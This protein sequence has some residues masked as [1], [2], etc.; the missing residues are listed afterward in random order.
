MRPYDMLQMSTVLLRVPVAEWGAVTSGWKR[1]FRGQSG[2]ASALWKVECPVPRVAF[3]LDSLGRYSAVLMLLGCVWRERLMG[4]RFL[5]GV[6]VHASSSHA[7]PVR[8]SDRIGG[9][10][11]VRQTPRNQQAS[12]AD[13]SYTDGVYPPPRAPRASH[14]RPGPPH[15]P[16]VG[17]SP[18]L[19][20]P[21][22]RIL[23]MQRPDGPRCTL[24]RPSHAA[25][26]PDAAPNRRRGGVVVCALSPDP[27]QSRD[28]ARPL[29][30]KC[31]R[32]VRRD[33]AGGPLWGVVTISVAEGKQL[34]VVDATW[35]PLDGDPRSASQT[36]DGYKAARALA[37]RWADQ[38]AAGR[39]PSS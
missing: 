29:D 31:S 21:R 30:D 24:D 36:V 25:T 9:E 12:R 19:G 8:L 39:E 16:H 3:K 34:L 10:F 23:R 26:P 37:H 17:G 22:V 27:L 6:E 11:G 5:D 20:V 15:F 32:P 28:A 14:G 35:K 38:L 4:A 7:Q 2:N 18:K 13:W 33:Q 1:E